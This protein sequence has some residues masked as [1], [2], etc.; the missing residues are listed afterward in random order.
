VRLTF[1]NPEVAWLLV[2]L[3][4]AAALPFL[5][6]GRPGR[7]RRWLGLALRLLV[8]TSLILALAGAQITRLVGDVTTIFLV[9][10]SDSVAPDE[11]ARAAD[12]IRRA[13]DHMAPGDRTGVVVFG[14]NAV[15]E[16]LPSEKTQLSRIASTPSAARTDIAGAVQLGQALLP[17]DTQ[18]RLVLLSDGQPNA[19]DAQ[20]QISLA[21]ARHIPID[22]VPLAP[23]VGD[24]EVALTGLH[25]PAG[26]R[27]GQRFDLTAVV[28]S[29]VPTSGQLRIW[30]DEVLIH[31]RSV[32]LTPG[33]DRI[34]AGVVADTQGFHRY[35]AQ[36]ETAV[37]TRPQNNIASTFGVIHGPPRVLVVAQRTED[38]QPLLGALQAADLKATM[39]D[40]GSLP[41]DLTEL[42]NYDSVVLANVPFA[43]LP[44]GAG[45]ELATF[46]RDLGHGL[47]MLGGD[48]SFGAGGY[49]RTPVETALP[50]AM[51]VRSRSQEPNV[52]LVM[53][54]D[55][56]GSMGRC[57]C[58]DPDGPS[59]RMEV[60]IPKV[61]IAKQAMIEASSV[62]SSFDYL[63][64]VAFDEQARWALETQPLVNPSTLESVVAGFSA[65]G[66]TNIMAGLDQAFESLGQVQARTKHVIL[67]TDGWT[68]AGG[69][70]TLVTQMHDRGITLSIVAAGRG[71]AAY[72]ERLAEAGG[73]KYYPAA[74]MDEV[75]RIFLKETVRTV[76]RLI[77]EEPTRPQLSSPSPLLRDVD[78]ASAPVLHGYNGA[79][80]KSAAVVALV[81]SEGDPLLAHWQYGLGRSVAWTSD[82]S[83]RWATDWL[84][85]AD[86]T[87][88]AAQL[89][90]WTL[91]APQ[92]AAL[93]T[94][95]QWNGEAV[96]IRVETVDTAGQPRTAE[97]LSGQIISPDLET[98]EVELA[99][100]AAGR[101]DGRVAVSETGS[102]LVHIQ[103]TRGGLPV[104][105]QTAGF[106]VPYSPEYTS[107]TV[108]TAFLTDVVAATGGRLAIE[109]SEAF[110]A[111]GQT[112]HRSQPIWTWLLLAALLLFP[113]DV[114]ARRLFVTRAD[115]AA[116][117]TWV[118]S[119]LWRRTTVAPNE[120]L[121]SE[122]FVA[123]KRAARRTRRDTDPP[124][125]V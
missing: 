71:S 16:R 28:A 1:A 73:G 116:A 100:T 24:A 63:G 103:E 80:A 108:D 95:V 13:L 60:G 102:Y 23:P 55:K 90:E 49:L 34:I 51:D 10:R 59:T 88:F 104:H 86:F 22:V 29:T 44:P 11:Q 91:P 118:A 87:A 37:D 101:Y 38:A 36:I 119:R 17:A 61:D 120:P 39:Q 62:L 84:S 121:L 123:K 7:P 48:Q 72:L 99:P 67:I 115:I 75:P 18:Q 107:L 109:P 41:T 19:G 124:A 21:A 46:V 58:D 89:V 31:E 15:V 2:L 111:T 14:A 70:D 65:E 92:S 79:T 82:L 9:D 122:L 42:A 57:H 50:V 125:D 83:G 96:T 6:R 52:A 33:L 105:T 4:A 74:S 81:T 66:G 64:V 35:R 20:L 27:I 12:F 78:A 54:L 3:P 43:S 77:V 98:T 32:R 47:V 45:E 53:A 40:P 8:L 26:V 110:D 76:G 69:Y 97:R 106:V 93:D 85:W 25:A 112:A 30:D 56:S 113:L 94:N 5:G 117:R 114:A 68:N